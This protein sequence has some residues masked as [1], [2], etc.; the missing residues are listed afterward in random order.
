MTWMTTLIHG[1]GNISK[2]NDE[3]IVWKLGS[4][5][6]NNPAANM[7]N[8]PANRLKTKLA[9]KNSMCF[10][11][12]YISANFGICSGTYFHVSVSL[13]FVQSCHTYMMWCVHISILLVLIFGVRMCIY[14]SLYH[15]I[16]SVLCPYKKSLSNS[17]GLD[18]GIPF[19][20]IPGR[21]LRSNSN[22][23]HVG[24]TNYI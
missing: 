19:F 17:T 23:V 7:K 2:Q 4:S 5:N 9:V 10:L 18:L 22:S 24:N 3:L 8:F 21:L 13:F 14:I 16:E 1:V 15:H 6:Q 12:K 20:G 11:H